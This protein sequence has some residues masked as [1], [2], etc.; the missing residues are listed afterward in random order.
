MFRKQCR[1]INRIKKSPDKLIMSFLPIEEL[2][3]NNFITDVI[4]VY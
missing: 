1:E 3:I 2:M 4:D